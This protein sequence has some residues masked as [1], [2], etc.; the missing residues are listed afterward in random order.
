MFEKSLYDLIRGLR[1]HKGKEREYI[2]NSLREC[3]AEIRGSDMDLKAT[4]LLKLIYLE[5]FGHDMSWASFHVLE[6]MSSPKYIQKRVG[7]L[8]AAQSF[9]PDTEVLMLATNLLKK[10]VSSALPL[11]ISLPLVTL[12]HVITASLAL[13]ILSDLLPRLSHSNPSIRKKTVVA[14]YRLALVHPDTLR[15]AWPKIKDLLMD[16][17]EDPSVTAATINVVCELGWRRP[18]DFLPLAPRLFELL[19]DGGNNWMAIKIIKL[20]ATLTP[21]EPRLV[22]KLLPP[23]TNLI[24]T[25]PAMSLLYECI[26]CIIQGGILESTDGLREGEEIAS[27]CVGKL[28]S[29]IEVEDDP[30]LRYVALLAFNH[31]V[32]SHAHLVS[33]HQ[34]AILSCIDDPD[35]SIRLQALELG[36]NMVNSD[37]LMAVVGRLMRQLRNNP[38]S[39]STDDIGRRLSGGVEPAADS[40]GEDPAATLRPVKGSMDD[41]LPLP[42]E[43]RASIIRR[44]L[45]MCSKDTY[46]NVNDFE[47][48]IETL[49]QLV[50]LVPP[51]KRSAD[52]TVI[53]QAHG[54]HDGSLSADEDIAAS[55]GLE[56]QNVAVRVNTVRAEAVSAAASLMAIDGGDVKFTNL[57]HGG[58]GVLRFAVWVAGEYSQWLPD[59]SETLTHA[60][61][62]RVQSLTPLTIS[63]YLQAIP[64]ILIRITS[65]DQSQWTP[66]RKSMVSLLLARVTH[67]LDPLTT[68]PSLEVQERC[69]ELLE[70][71]RVASQAVTDHDTD[72][73]HGPL[74]LTR[75]IPSLYTGE[76]IKPVAP[77]AQKKVPL[78]DD[79]DLD[80]PLNENLVIL[81]QRA[82]QDSLIDTES[83]EFDAFYNIRPNRKPEVTAAADTL[84]P[85]EPESVSYQQTEGGTLDPETQAKKR[86]E[87]R[88]RNKDDPF[89]IASD[90][91][92]SGSSTPF[93]DIIRNANGEDVDVDS[94]PIMSLDLGDKVG[95][96]ESSD[97][98]P[99]KPLKRK[100]PRKH[101]VVAMDENIDIS[102]P[103][104]TDRITDPRTTANGGLAS[105]A[106]GRRA[107]AKKSLLEVDSSGLGAFSLDDEGSQLDVERQQVEDA[108]MAKAL[109]EVERLRMEMQRASE[110]VQVQGI[111]PEGELVKKKK[112]KKRKNVLGNVGGD[113]A[114][115]P[116]GEA[117]DSGDVVVK[118]RKK[119]KKRAVGGEEGAA[120]HGND[121]VDD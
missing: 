86:Q 14:L 107:R 102:G 112:K 9:R 108:D 7:Y 11:T 38:L 58:E 34:D 99:R 24:R 59:P 53:D 104:Q 72:S 57:G 76:E 101:H 74:L 4:A 60:F 46:S 68:H 25:T 22:K 89:Y 56:L 110:R 30:N 119:K 71:M 31:I 61:Q 95:G 85:V 105:P 81:L 21:L 121:G 2:Q 84:P 39:I 63:A 79:L 19:V 45:D 93:H 88:I 73:D 18:K 5:M 12:P 17:E 106:P 115:A 26:N 15:P 8:G 48:Y 75:A 120:A 91:N 35:I 55:I 103:P 51:I 111:P 96:A 118:K 65:Q 44:I 13:S 98:E 49:V 10:D 32:S 87:R 117:E 97:P 41:A 100:Q 20:F 33:L 109:A 83:V 77:T 78:P 43:Y 114:V 66:E 28:R 62:S 54:H 40:E 23:L 6:V 82:D 67:F 80:T 36:V 92:V 69:V 1:N 64:K 94:I 116:E 90:D 37:N 47:W 29:M 3:R 113:D 42:A 70:L 27:L 50:A 52:R 16:E